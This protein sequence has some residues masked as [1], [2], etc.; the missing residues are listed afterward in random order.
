MDIGAGV[1]HR[2]ELKI[3]YDAEMK[4]I[5]A[6]CAVCRE[7]MPTPPE[8][9]KDTAEIIIWLSLVYLQNQMQKHSNEER[10]RMPRD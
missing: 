2:T 6:M 8:D 7:Q 5:S 3:E 10:R 4:P 1:M 9:L